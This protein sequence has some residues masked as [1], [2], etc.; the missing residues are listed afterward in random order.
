MSIGVDSLLINEWIITRGHMRDSSVPHNL[1]DFVGDYSYV[2]P[3]SAYDTSEIYAYIFENK[4]SLLV[5]DTYKRRG[6]VK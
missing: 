3:D 2:L 5:I 4:F 6:I 1:T